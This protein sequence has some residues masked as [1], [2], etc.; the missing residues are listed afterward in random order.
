MKRQTWT[1]LLIG[2]AAAG[3]ATEDSGA[4]DAGMADEDALDNAAD[5]GGD[6]SCPAGT[7]EVTYDTE[8]S[9]EQNAAAAGA[10]ADEDDEVPVRTLAAVCFGWGTASGCLQTHATQIGA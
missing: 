9:E 6:G 8:W 1:L 3:D 2:A 10:V 4:D 7:D 5:G